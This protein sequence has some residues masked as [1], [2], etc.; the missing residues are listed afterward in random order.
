LKGKIGE[1]ENREKKNLEVSEEYQKLLKSKAT[2][3]Q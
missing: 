3:I 2:E 1:V